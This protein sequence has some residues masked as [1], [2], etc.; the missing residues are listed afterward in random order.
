M[1]RFALAAALVAAVL[2]LWLALRA[3][4][5]A[6]ATPVT[7]TGTIDGATPERAARPSP[8]AD[9]AAPA[10]PHASGG[11]SR[12][13]DTAVEPA[14]AGA[15]NHAASAAPS[16]ARDPRPV[17][18]PRLPSSAGHRDDGELTDKTGWDP[19]IMKAFN[20][21]FMPLASECVALARHRHP[22]LEGL[23]A[24]QVNIAPGAD[25]KVLVAS[26]T[27]RPDN[28]ILDPE[29]FEC[30]EQSSF[31]LDGLDAPHDFDIT[32]PIAPPR[33]E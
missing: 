3:H 2:G 8:A 4:G 25:D 1:R 7:S 31:A 10:Q 20:H 14:A 29:L 27:R 30:I 17:A 9:R 21:A 5:G 15:M 24:F 19:A 6:P 22:A 16:P 26:L 23:L 28:Q 32:M 11:V 33:P 18:P 12:E 13:R